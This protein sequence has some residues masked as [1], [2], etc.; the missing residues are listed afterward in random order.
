MNFTEVK[1][2][3]NSVYFSIGKD[4]RTI[5]FSSIL[6]VHIDTNQVERGNHSGVLI[7]SIHYRPQ[8][9]WA[10]VMFLQASVILLTGGG[11][12][13]PQCM[14]GYTPRSRPPPGSRLR[15]TVNERPVRILL[16]CILVTKVY[17]HL[18]KANAKLP[19]C[20]KSL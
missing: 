18:V 5:K 6:S 20:E 15:H 4:L 17:S 13:L 19:G 16:E 2:K 7:F 10:K 9:S 11:G 8:R 14:L 1:S 3:R 12:S